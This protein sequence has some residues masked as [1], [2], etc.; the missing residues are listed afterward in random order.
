MLK[1]RYNEVLIGLNL[2]S[3]VRGLISRRRGR[4]VLLIDDPRFRAMSYPSLFLSEL[5]IQ[6]LQRLGKNFEIPELLELRDFLTE[7]NLEL[8]LGKKRLKLG[9]SPLENLRELLRKFPVLLDA[10]DLDL[11]YGANEDFNQNFLKELARFEQACFDSSSRSKGVR[12][13]L[14]GPKWLKTIYSRFADLLN[15]E[16]QDTKSLESRTLL[17]LVGLMS[18]EKLKAR[19]EPEDIPF[20]FFRMLSPAYR[21]QDFFISTQLRRRLTLLGGDFKESSVQFWQL[22]ENRFEN[23]LLESFEGVISGERVLFCSHLPEEVPF[24]V[25]SPYHIFRKTQVIPQKRAN[26]PFP[27]SKISFFTEE[28]VL[29]S[30]RPYRTLIEHE[31]GPAAYHWPYPELPGSKPDFYRKHCWSM[32]DEDARF[33]P[34]TMKDPVFQGV[35]GVTLDMR[36]HAEY[37]KSEASV[38]GRLPLDLVSGEKTV[39]G[40]EYWGPFRYRSHGFLALCYGVQGN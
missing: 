16:Y 1:N 5:E 37:R 29:G 19:M 20:Y 8:V 9:S 12:F 14:Q 40:F 7:G 31:E 32:F 10:S 22:H 25:L 21:L 11:V 17:H 18:E 36:K 26:S 15:G 28:E 30:D 39:Q 38:L 27:A 13:D 4:S 3:L 33:F 35:Q 24:R 34:F 6:A 23:L 2:T